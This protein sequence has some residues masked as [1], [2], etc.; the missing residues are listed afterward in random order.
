MSPYSVDLVLPPR[1]TGPF[2][3]SL[4]GSMVV[5]LL[6][7]TLW[8]SAPPSGMP[9]GAVLQVTLVSG[10]VATPGS[11]PSQAASPSEPTAA[12][13]E[14]PSALIGEADKMAASEPP[15][16]VA[17][18]Q[19]WEILAV[20]GGDSPP[21]GSAQANRRDTESDPRARGNAEPHRG[22]PA[23]PKEPSAKPIRRPEQVADTQERALD[24]VAAAGSAP[25]GV[26]NEAVRTSGASPAEGEG[27]GTGGESYQ[28]LQAALHAALLPRFDYPLLA[29]RRGWEGRVRV[30]LIVEPDGDLRDVHVVESSGFK[31]LDRAAVQ[32]L[33]EVGTLTTVSGWLGGAEMDVTLPVQYRLR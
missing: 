1:I 29:R 24:H 27:G 20:A 21:A 4:L 16:S 23:E 33:E 28:A 19:R 8:T 22:R 32:D 11:T 30:G 26:N 12:P 3:V 18:E 14:D 10:D 31:V 7:L 25:E 15:A 17:S 2:R 5:H 13:L 9:G 6:A